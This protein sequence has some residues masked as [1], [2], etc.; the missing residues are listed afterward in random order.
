[1]KEA[2]KFPD[3][4]G[5]ASHR[6]TWVQRKQGSREGCRYPKGM[7]SLNVFDFMPPALFTR[8]GWEKGLF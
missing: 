4:K 5:S 2:E 1:M 7:S 8:L 6:G 3:S